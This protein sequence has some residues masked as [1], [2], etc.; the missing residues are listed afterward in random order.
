MC[1]K[2][3]TP[4]IITFGIMENLLC[5]GVPTL[6]HITVCMNQRWLHK[7]IGP[8]SIHFHMSLATFP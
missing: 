5:L 3:G 6:K 7:T 8:G 1:L 4:K 2:F